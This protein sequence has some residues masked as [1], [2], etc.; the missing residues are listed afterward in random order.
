[1]TLAIEVEGVSKRF[2]IPLDR[3]TTLKYR[4][5][6]LRSSGRYQDLYAL[7]DVSMQIPFGSFV[8]I[9][10]ANG[11]G[12]STLLKILAG[13][14]RPTGGRVAVTGH[15]SP[16]LEL[17]VG[18]N[19]ELTARENVYLNGAVLGIRRSAL[20]R[21]IDDIIGFAELERFADQ[22]LKNFSSGMQVRLAFSVAIQA[23]AGIL[24]MDEV[25][26]VGDARFQERCLDIF[27]RYKREGRTVVLVTHDLGAVELYCDH[28]FLLDHG[29]LVAQGAAGEVCG[30]YRR[31]VG[32]QQ[33]ADAAAASAEAPASTLDSEETATR[34]G[35]G[36]VRVTDVEFLGA[37]GERHHTFVAGQPL[38]VRIHG[39]V[40]RR[41]DDIVCGV[42]IHRDDGLIIAGDNTFFSGLEMR[43][44][45]TGQQFT[46]DYAV[47][48]LR[49]LGGHYRVTVALAAHPTHRQIDHV[50]QAFDFRVQSPSPQWGLLSM[51][52]HWRAPGDLLRPLSLGAVG[53]YDLE[54]P[55]LSHATTLAERRE[56]TA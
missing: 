24:L 33:D 42:G 51:G 52:A 19:P 21:R 4:L 34:W 13:I 28:A 39:H 48:E 35:T 29:R 53:R 6:H 15:V 36:E 38:T 41:V 23:D 7:H 5:S 9:V 2:R 43:C 44:P 18:F 49:L 26:A 10:G 47:D 11:C 56:N 1:V 16:F 50:E 31:L 30:A 37:D 32:E 27:T 17:G 3:S 8:G 14:Y 25:L 12:K 45:P 55:F 40:H 46:I 20:H 54:P 22:K